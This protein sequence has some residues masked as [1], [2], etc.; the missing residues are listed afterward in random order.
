V[1]LTAHP[2]FAMSDSRLP[3]A[4]SRDPDGN[5]TKKSAQECESPSAL[6]L[7]AD[8]TS[9]DDTT[10]AA[11]FENARAKIKGSRSG[12]TLFAYNRDEINRLF[13]VIDECRVNNE[14]FIVAASITLAGFGDQAKDKFQYLCG[15][16]LIYHDMDTDKMWE[17][18][19]NCTPG[20]RQEAVHGLM[21]WAR[22]DNL[23]SFEIWMTGCLPPKAIDVFQHGDRGLASIAHSYLKDVVKLRG[24]ERPRKFYL[25]DRILCLWNLVD[26]G[27]V[28]NE[29]SIT[30]E[31]VLG[32]II[33]NVAV[34]HAK[35]TDIGQD[36]DTLE[37]VFDANLK[38]LSA[39][40]ARIRNAGGLSGII[41][42]MASM[43]VDTK[44]ESNLDSKPD[45]L[46][47]QNGVVDLRTG[48]LRHRT[49]EDAIFRLANSKYDPSLDS[50]W[51]ND[52]VMSMMADDQEM[53]A[54]LQRFLGYCIT[55]ERQEEVFTFFTSSG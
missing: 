20:K 36:E 29:V 49:P 43:C 51:F 9:H 53:V 6:I 28:K 46:G 22:E 50:K 30:L 47:V 45:L 7:S 34:E 21:N 42:F 3:L 33:D 39:S 1:Q 44:F 14:E 11:A 52:I 12:Q 32:K 27:A 23:K 25:F 26:D 18:A 17:R 5:I 16:S 15:E 19:R 31:M 40:I 2:S 37:D 54:F 4:T 35:R 48:E 41:T 10:L 38:F 13:S 8:G 55:G 24:N